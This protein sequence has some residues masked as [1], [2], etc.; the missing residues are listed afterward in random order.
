MIPPRTINVNKALLQAF[1]PKTEF[2]HDSEA[3]RVF[4]SN[5]NLDSVHFELLKKMIGGQG[6][7]DWR[8]SPASH[9]F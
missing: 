3:R 7:G 5:I 8:H 6:N 9:R 1:L 2:F 4:G